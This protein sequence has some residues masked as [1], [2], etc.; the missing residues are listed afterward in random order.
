VYYQEV[1]TEIKRSSDKFENGLLTNYD[2]F[3]A[4]LKKLNYKEI[5]KTM[6]LI[7]SN[8]FALY[9]PFQIDLSIYE[10]V[11]EFTLLDAV[12]LTDG[13]L[14]GQKVWDEF[15]ALNEINQFAKKK[16]TRAK[17]NSLMQFFTFTLLKFNPKQQLPYYSYEFGGYYF[18]DDLSFIE[19]GKFNRTKYL[20]KKED[21]FL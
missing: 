13:K 11:K 6:T 5:A 9:F 17:I 1:L 2:N 18:V 20:A 4:L 7:S 3:A 12:F 15:T 8:T 21:L 19:E 16:V 10:G 14:D